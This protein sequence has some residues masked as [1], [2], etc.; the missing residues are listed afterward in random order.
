M[1]RG[2]F[3]ERRNSSPVKEEGR[4]SESRGVFTRKR[5]EEE[6]HN[7]MEESPPRD[8]LTLILQEGRK[9]FQQED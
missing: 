6:S 3:H 9:I 8:S 2:I 4:E 1:K 7:K 5:R